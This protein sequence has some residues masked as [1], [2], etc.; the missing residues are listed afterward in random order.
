MKVVQMIEAPFLWLWEP[1]FFFFF[2]W[3]SK[4]WAQ[5]GQV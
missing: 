1:I 2:W 5:A 3:C 4:V